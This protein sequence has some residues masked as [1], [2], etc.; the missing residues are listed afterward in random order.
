MDTSTP[1]ILN[2]LPSWGKDP[3]AAFSIYD[4]VDLLPSQKNRYN[5]LCVIFEYNATYCVLIFKIGVN[6]QSHIWGLQ[7]PRPSFSP[8][9]LP[10]QHHEV[11]FA[12]THKANFAYTFSPKWDFLLRLMAALHL[13]LI[14]MKRKVRS[15]VLILSI[16]EKSLKELRKTR[17]IEM[18]C[19]KT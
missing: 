18:K 8:H 5:I 7:A 6:Q 3:Q 2:F 19:L 4:P 11:N 10:P 12:L 15:N 17:N 14:M 9:E 16:M 13:L 1:F